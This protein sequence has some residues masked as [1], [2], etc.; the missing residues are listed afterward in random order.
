M[1]DK[2][3]FED[4]KVQIIFEHTDV[5]TGLFLRDALWFT[6]TEYSAMTE[7]DVDAIKQS[8]ID[9]WVAHVNAVN[10]QDNTDSPA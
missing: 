9:T 5:T 1:A 6:Q 10:V 4:D 8:R 3:I 7:A 2:I